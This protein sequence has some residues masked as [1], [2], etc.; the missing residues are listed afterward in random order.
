[1]TSTT[2]VQDIA[3]Q[4]ANTGTFATGT[5]SGPK[6]IGLSDGRYL[7]AWQS[8]DD[9]ASSNDGADLF[10]TIYNADGTVFATENRLNLLSHGDEIE[11]DIAAVDDGGFTYAFTR[12][13][14]GDLSTLGTGWKIGS[15]FSESVG[16]L[17]SESLTTR[18]L[19]Q[20]H[21]I[22]DLVSGNTTLNIKDIGDGTGD[23]LKSLEYPMDILSETFT[24]IVGLADGDSLTD[25][26]VLQDGSIARVGILANEVAFLTLHDSSGTEI[27]NSVTNSAQVPF[28]TSSGSRGLQ[29]TALA[30]GG[31]VALR[32]AEWGPADNDLYARIYT[33]SGTQ[34][35][36]I[37]VAS[38]FNDESFGDIIGLPTGGFAVSYVNSASGD[39]SVKVYDDTGAPVGTPVIIGQTQTQT[40]MS[41]SADGKLLFAWVDATS[42]EIMSSVWD[43]RGLSID[44][45]DFNLNGSAFFSAPT[46]YGGDLGGTISGTIDDD[47]IV[48]G[49]GNDNIFGGAGN[50]LLIGSDGDD[51][52]TGGENDDTLYSGN[53]LDTLFGGEGEDSFYA[54]NTDGSASNDLHQDAFNGQGGNDRFFISDLDQV[55]SINGGADFDTI[56][57]KSV[58][59]QIDVSIDTFNGGQIGIS[60]TPSSNQFTDIQAIE[61]GS[62]NDTVAFSAGSDASII[63]YGYG[64][65]DTFDAFLGQ[66][67]SSFY[68]GIGNDTFSDGTGDQSYDGG[69]G[70][71]TFSAGAGSDTMDGGDGNDVFTSLG[72]FSDTLY[73][74]DGND[75]FTIDQGGSGVTIDGGYDIDTL[76]V[77]L[78]GFNFI[79]GVGPTL[80]DFASIEGSSF[81]ASNIETI[82]LGE[83]N[84]AVTATGI[85]GT[86][87]STGGGSDT[88]TGGDANEIFHGDAGNDEI[89]GGGGNDTLYGGSNDDIIYGGNGNDFI[90]AG[91][92]EIG[93]HN[94]TDIVYGGEGNDHIVVSYS[95]SSETF[96][97]GLDIDTMDIS[98]E[99]ASFSSH[100]LSETGGVAFF[101]AQ[102]EGFENIIATRFSDQFTGNS[103]D[104]SL[105]G[106]AGND[107][108]AGAV[109]NDTLNGGIGN[110]TLFGG[111][112]NDTATYEDASGSVTVDLHIRRSFGA[113]GND[114]LREIEGAEGSDHGDIMRGS[115]FVGD[116]LD[117]GG[118][119]DTLVGR[120]GLDTMIGGSGDDKFFAQQDGDIVI[121][122]AD[123]GYDSVRVYFDD[124]VLADNVEEGRVIGTARKLYGNDD[125]NLLVGLGGGDSLH[126][127]AGND[128]INGNGGG[129][130][131][132]GDG[133]E[134]TLRGGSGSDTLYGGHQ[135]DRLEGG[136]DI[137]T[138]Y[139][140]TGEDIIIGGGNRDFMTGGANADR[141]V[142]TDSGFGGSTAAFADRIMDFSQ[143]QG[144][145][146]DLRP[147]FAN[148]TAASNEAFTFVGANAFDG[149]AG[150]LN[151]VQVGGQ[152]RIA[153]DT[154]GDM[155]ADYMI[156]LETLV[157]LTEDDFL[158]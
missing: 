135:A 69:E 150:Q 86:T 105:S 12:H 121:E 131:L 89:N 71:D 9:D 70:N 30:N 63:F 132:W 148:S 16:T 14:E 152:T 79:V 98:S 107:E 28:S 136:D 154:D 10:K 66:G 35:E 153:M 13:A 47:H 45:A 155:I 25:V 61:L 127:G 57:A 55:P 111:D 149:T 103:Y 81:S 49:A 31:F 18:D 84:D 144:D 125:D 27:L 46:V 141:F 133:G 129:D 36:L 118:G 74:G 26:A 123:E 90:N 40:D 87:V 97:G 91:I 83:G 140:G 54:G 50:D 68:G 88:I 108:I 51:V 156:R 139:G 11:F 17:L 115:A 58:N 56:D 24:D 158:L 65:N 117:G 101:G 34:G 32:T 130:R 122:T 126:G 77:S 33:A 143:S 137:D 44:V 64:G 37:V 5:Q 8:A 119:N 116:T 146:I 52:I 48:G 124:Y 2:P 53:G 99:S 104:N 78:A 100:T 147:V 157:D 3:A 138:F 43:P 110:D 112:G 72:A 23:I 1:M 142:F 94:G 82:Q 76:N 62:G 151:Y 67:S 114:T 80:T 42:G 4:Q 95:N 39:I 113:D 73:G 19:G 106:M 7:V 59:G 38:S 75:H 96:D 120:G 85:H 41:V 6:I 92:D 60:S 102:F 15:N 29:V 128:F 22:K 145:Q 134:D 20:V 109:G 21:L 93:T